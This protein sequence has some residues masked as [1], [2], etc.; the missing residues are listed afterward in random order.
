MV[1]QLDSVPGLSSMI[2][3]NFWTKA[4]RN[5]PKA[6]LE[7]PY[8]IHS[9]GKYFKCVKNFFFRDIPNG[10]WFWPIFDC[11]NLRFF[12]KKK[13]SIYKFI[14]N[15]KIFPSEDENIFFQKVDFWTRNEK[16]KKCW[17]YSAY[18]PLAFEQFFSNYLREIRDQHS[19]SSCSNLNL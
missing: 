17:R 11:R 3:H 8:Y 10:T 18:M 4:V 2:G 1:L 12:Q 16:L 13:I 7:S 5:Y 19:S 6:V 9:M 14:E 15:L